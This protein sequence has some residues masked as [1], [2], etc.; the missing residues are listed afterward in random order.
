MGHSMEWI[1]REFR[2]EDAA[3]LAKL[4][5]ESEEGWPGG[6]TGGIPYTAER[7]LDRIRSSNAIIH[8]VAEMNGQI[9]GYLELDWHWLGKDSSY[10]SLINV[11]PSY[12][13][14]GIGTNLLK[15]AILKSIEVGVD[16]V[17]LHTWPGNEGAIR[18]YKKLGFFWV[19][20]TRV[21]MQNYLPMIV[22]NPIARDFF[23][24]NLD[25]LFKAKREVEVKEDD[26]KIKGRGVY[27]YEW[28]RDGSKLKVYVDRE[29]WG[30][31][32]VEWNGGIIESYL[33]D[34]EVIRGL[35]TTVAWRMC[36]YSNKPLTV[37]LIPQCD[38]GVK[39]VERPKSVI[40]V[41][42]NDE[43]VVKGK[44]LVNISA[45][46][47]EQDE[48]ALKVKSLTLLDGRLMDL[49]L[50]LKSD[51]PVLVKLISPLS[52][53]PK[54]KG[55]LLLDVE[56]NT[57]RRISSKLNII[58][59]DEVEVKPTEIL[60]ELDKEE[61]KTIPLKLEVKDPRTSKAD[62]TV[63]SELTIGGKRIENKPYHF[64][65]AIQRPGEVV[66]YFDEE[67]RRV[68]IHKGK[69]LFN[70]QL[71]G[72]VLNVLDK[73]HDVVVVYHRG[74][75]LG[76][77]FW[78]D[79][80]SRTYYD[81]TLEGDRRYLKLT[82]RAKLKKYP[83]VELRKTFEFF[84]A[85]PLVK[86]AYEL[87][88][89]TSRELNLKLETRFY[90]SP[91]LTKSIAVPLKDGVL[92]SQIVLGDFPSSKHDLPVSPK[93]YSEYWSCYTLRNRIVCGLL[94][95][96]ENLSEIDFSYYKL[97]SLKYEV[98]LKPYSV[99]RLAPL[100][101]YI[102]DGSWR[103][104]EESYHELYKGCYK[105]IKRKMLKLIEL[106]TD[107]FPLVVCDNYDLTTKLIVSKARGKALKGLVRFAPDEEIT[108]EPSK[109]EVGVTDKLS[110]LGTLKLTLKTSKLGVYYVN[111]EL[112]SNMGIL[113]DRIPVI[114]IGERGEVKVSKTKEEGKEAWI[115]DNGL[116]LVKCSPEFGGA[117]YAIIKKG[118]RVN[119]LLTS[120]PKPRS[121]SWMSEWHGG[122]KPSFNLDS[123]A[124][125][126]ER[127]R[128]DYSSIRE[129]V[130][131][132][133]WTTVTSEEHR[134]YR[135]LKVVQHYLTRPFSNVI[136][137]LTEIENPTEKYM[138]TN[139]SY[140]VFSSPGGKMA[141]HF[142]VF[143]EGKWLEWKSSGYEVAYSTS[144]N[145]QAIVYNERGALTL[146]SSDEDGFY[147]G[148]IVMGLK[149]GCHLYLY[150]EQLD[151]LRPGDTWRIVSYLVL[152][153]SKEE[154]VN[155]KW[156]KFL[157]P[158]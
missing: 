97:P 58:I 27:V 96:E 93:E 158:I 50:G 69:L 132:K 107:P 139:Y 41:K 116:Y 103:D 36:N 70:F 53:Y 144:D 106:K 153:E 149:H 32:G 49:V 145:G 4:F 15:K 40:E 109:F 111:Y 155:Y 23:E 121:F 61:T 117:L 86:V 18:L 105:F 138:E 74:E 81:F 22:K 20:K 46:K 98:V 24:D 62:M 33:E 147:V 43:V 21:Y 29:A 90:P 28:M 131:V 77:P 54:F 52:L 14:R 104:V 95:S 133:V 60:V 6:F 67:N 141:N 150:A 137:L 140:Y 45:P 124:L 17:D 68:L 11:H 48:P 110:E 39:L 44:V 7:V 2:E 115:I 65:M 5:N 55:D 8:Y 9:V 66:G 146:I 78:P 125:Q 130:G 123:S 129:W 102:G 154:A 99:L 122:L 76:P 83:G 82:L 135:G 91:W 38:S 47:R 80:L 35:E 113:K 151:Y 42:P 57:K 118:K 128:A 148:A 89:N 127:W 87:T 34:D 3:K 134:E 16:R 13:R 26:L 94:W 64:T 30:I 31:C 108:V 37:T 25:F 120:F 63:L 143:S 75:S 152:T 85:S 79:E 1:I 114:V 119:N 72:G 51:Y 156:L 157:K 100:Y 142:S 12:R 84:G 56:N 59:G 101:V 73:V 88:N 92:V 71:R 10:I 126:R 136:L 112:S 19:P